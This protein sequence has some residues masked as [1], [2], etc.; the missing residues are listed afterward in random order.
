[1]TDHWAIYLCNVNDSPAT[2]YLNLGLRPVAPMES[3]SLL[4]WVW[5]S[6]KSPRPDGLFSSQ[7]SPTLYAIEDALTSRLEKECHAQFAG[8]ISTQGR[9]EIYFFTE[10]YIGV[11]QSVR[12]ALSGFEGYK[13][14]IGSQEDPEWKQYFEVLHP[15]PQD[16]QR[17]WNCELLER[18]KGLGDIPAIPRAVNHWI[19]FPSTRARALFREVVCLAGFEVTSEIPGNGAE[20]YGIVLLRRQAIEQ[21]LID[22]TVIEL[23]KLA[24]R[25][26]GDYDGWETQVTGN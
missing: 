25:F 16:L 1:M 8:R 12:K 17:I 22:A 5:V 10:S 4:I 19:Y 7:G 9:S 13:F 14:D 24:E 18:L 15:S 21:N 11:E 26:Q 20:P 3:K 6:C 2:I 23:M